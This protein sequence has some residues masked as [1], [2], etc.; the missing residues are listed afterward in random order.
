[1]KEVLV[2]WGCICREAKLLKGELRLASSRAV[3]IVFEGLYAYFSI[4]SLFI[5]HHES[6]DLVID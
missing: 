2:S 6:I 3:Y 5:N 4:L 1:M